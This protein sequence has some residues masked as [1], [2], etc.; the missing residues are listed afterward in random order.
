MEKQEKP[1]IRPSDYALQKIQLGKDVIRFL[2]IKDFQYEESEDGNESPFI[3]K[4]LKQDVERK[5]G[6]Y[7][8]SLRRGAVIDE[9][10][11]AG[12]RLEIHGPKGTL[13][14]E[15]GMGTVK[16]NGKPIDVDGSNIELIRCLTEKFIELRKIIEEESKKENE[17]RIQ[18]MSNGIGDQIKA[19]DDF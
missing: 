14:F 2:K 17:K 7:T 3:S 9:D 5:A 10:G 18:E 12:G 4:C 1:A 19:I 8:L 6:S 11:V 13:Q 15:H 16:L